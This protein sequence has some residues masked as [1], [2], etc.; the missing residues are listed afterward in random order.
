MLVYDM[1]K[2]KREEIVE[3]I[4]RLDQKETVRI[5]SL[6]FVYYY[7]YPA[8]SPADPLQLGSQLP[9]LAIVLLD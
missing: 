7:Y 3:N 9:F 5:A 1:S 6:P 2:I 4:S 8:S